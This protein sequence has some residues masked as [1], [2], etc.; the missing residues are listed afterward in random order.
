MSKVRIVVVDDEPETV[1][2][3]KMYMEMMGFDVATGLTGAEGIKAVET[4][5]PQVLVL[6][7]MLPDTDG[8]TICETLRAKPETADLPIVI[9]SA[10]TARED[11]KR[12]YTVGA[13]LYLKK[14]VDLHRL[15]TEVRRLAD[16]GK[17]IAPPESEQE[18]H[19]KERSTPKI[20]LPATN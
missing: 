10:R 6:D 1:S 20:I 13:S 12:G 7:L 2:L 8:Y 4:H 15:N 16:L 11:V 5:Q 3:I 9:L 19:A 17:H 14:P 18:E